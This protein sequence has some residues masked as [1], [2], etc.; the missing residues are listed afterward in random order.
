MEESTVEERKTSWA[1][2]LKNYIKKNEN[3]KSSNSTKDDELEM[4][5]ELYKKYKGLHRE[6]KNV[7]SLY[8]RVPTEDEPLLMKLREE[9]S[10]L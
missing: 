6:H 2:S 5:T 10:S 1:K 8:S 3:K 7:P 4:F 9:S